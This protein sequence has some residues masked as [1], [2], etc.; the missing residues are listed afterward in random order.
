M[1]DLKKLKS[2]GSKTLCTLVILAVAAI[3]AFS[4]FYVVDETESVVVTRFG[5]YNQTV[6]AGLHFKLPFGID[7]TYTV[8]VKVV[9][10]EQFGFKTVKAG[11][12]NSGC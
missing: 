12:N 3:A 7:K 10:T 11:R 8:P 5:K 9:Q 1:P 6:N 4:S 2:F